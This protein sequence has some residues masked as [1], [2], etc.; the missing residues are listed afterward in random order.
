MTSITVHRIILKK[1]DHQIFCVRKTLLAQHKLYMHAWNDSIIAFL[2]IIAKAESE[3]DVCAISGCDRM[4]AEG[5]YCSKEHKH[6]DGKYAYMHLFIYLIPV[7]IL[8]IYI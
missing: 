6:E 8:Y 5:A 2:Y 7:D 4:R 3:D 1:G